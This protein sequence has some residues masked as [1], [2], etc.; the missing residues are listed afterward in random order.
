MKKGSISI[1]KIIILAILSIGLLSVGAYLSSLGGQNVGGGSGTINPLPIK[2]FLGLT[3]TPNTYSGQTLKVVRVNGAETAL[4]FATLAGGGDALVA[5]PLSQFAATTSLELAGVISDE[6]GSGALVFANSPVF[7]TPNIGSATGSISGNAGT[8]T[9]LAANGANCSAGSYPLGVDASGAVESCTVS[10]SGSSIIL[11]FGDDGENDSTTLAEIVTSGDTNGIF[12]EPSADKL[13]IDLTKDWPKS[14]VADLVT[15]ADAGGDTTTSVALGTAATGNLSPATDA[16]L[17]YNAT[18]DA[19]TTTTFIGALS[20]NSTTATALAANPADCAANQFATT[21]AASGALTCAAIVD[22]DV[23]NT[24]TID[25][26]TNATTLANARTI[27]GVS[28]NGSANITVASATGNFSI[29]N[30][31]TS[32]GVLT[33]LEDTDTGSNFASFQVPTLAGDT[34]YI[35]P[36][37]DGDAGEQLQTNGTG[38]LSWEAAGS[39]GGGLAST[40]IDTCAELIAIQTDETGTCG[41][42]VFS[43]SPTFDDDIQIATAGVLLTGADGVLTILGS[44]NGNDE[45]LTFDF[46]NGTA[47]NVDIASGTAVSQINWTGILSF[48]TLTLSGTG[49]LNGLDAIDATGEATL[50]SALDIAGDIS[51]T[52]LSTTVIGNDKILEVMLKAVDSAVDEECLTYESTTGDFEWQTCGGGSGASTAL[53][54]LA[55]VA[56]NA[57]LT[58]ATSDA[59]ALGSTTKQWGDLFLAEG[60]IINWDNG[61]A[62]L[63]QTANNITFAGINTFEVGTSTALTLGTVEL[64]AASDTTLARV[65]AGLISVEGITL[66]DVS[67]SQTLTNK[68]LTSPT[69]TTPSAFTTGGV[70]TLAENT[71]I[72][73]DPAGSAD[74]KYTG[75]TVAGTAGTTLA[76]GDVVYLAAADSRWELTDADAASTSGDVMVGIVV[77]AAASDGSATTILLKGIIRAD[78]NFPTM[79]ISGQVYISTTA[80][81][82]QVAQPSGTDDVIRVLG[83]ALTA[84]EFYFNPSEDYFTHI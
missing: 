55:S 26:A 24:I 51:S 7:T 3:D 16:G 5:D 54:N 62:T 34:V 57:S 8:A 75:I 31:A 27:G 11:D 63:T 79:T 43:N 76:F 82:V 28:F 81:D 36:A 61:D 80:G 39:G 2:T 68:T 14:D 67:T 29:S 84:D 49:T 59:F 60:G 83:R 20:G 77:L 4:E 6:T 71:S 13:L 56:I 17:T 45:N 53:D 25:L 30:G 38:T 52:G 35:L 66:V 64:G 74:G 1:F 50:E 15:F 18:T 42:L 58:L 23:P 48:P 12:T 33:L 44:G 41:A 69:L 46:D 78:S 65:S 72:A 37:D 70:I 10:G 19:L 21:I 73:L 9:A 40:D 47:N 22:A 32:A